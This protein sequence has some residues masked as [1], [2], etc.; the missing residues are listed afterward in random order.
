MC[1]YQP[2]A[3]GSDVL[4]FVLQQHLAT[5][6]DVCEQAGRPVP[7]YVERELT[8]YL[9]CGIL[10]HGF[11]LLRCDHCDAT[12]V[13]AFSCKRR[14]FCPSC[15]GRQMNQTAAHLVDRVFPQVP[16]R[17]WVLSLPMP[18]RFRLLWDKTLCQSVLG[19]FLKAVYGWYR[20]QA[21]ELGMGKA[22]CGSVTVEQ[23]F[24]SS[25]NANLHYHSVCVDGWYTEDEMGRPV[26]HAAVPPTTEEVA[27]VV[28]EVV[29][30]VWRLLARRGLL[31]ADELVDDA[32]GAEDGQ[33]VMQDASVAGRVALGLRAGRRPRCL[34]GSP[35]RA[36]T[37]P[38][39][40]AQLGYFNLHAGVRIA[41]YDREGRER[42]FRYICRP[43]L[44]GDR[45]TLRKD[46]QV[47]VRFKRP[48][49]DGT[50][51]IVLDPLDFIA[52]LA[53]IVPQPRRN[54]VHYHGV[55][56]PAAKLRAR[57]VPAPP[58]AERQPLLVHS[59]PQK[60][61]RAWIPW[62]DLMW[63][64]FS[65]EAMTCS[66]GCSMRVHAV[67]QGV[68]ATRRVLSC[69]GL[70]SAMPRLLPARAPPEAA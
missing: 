39:Q 15:V 24:G 10:A 69:L 54:K 25:L 66:C 48:W 11:T 64:V 8:D 43:P 17:Q 44:A 28:A 60:R 27:S 9:A 65:V 20:R 67:V 16:V 3:R 51:A 47:V 12:R 61:W 62:A 58:P 38:R 36:R 50:S 33:R 57:I 70:P 30:R 22:L 23:A 37:L 45:L 18:L 32:A 68:W 21:G 7:G 4:Y 13:V 6:L 1:P 42:L 53:A 35:G 40:C 55:F 46:G 63:R 14:G 19:V 34:R 59:A 31:E 29:R 2:A 5:F 52:R 26:F 56:G 41:P 49:A